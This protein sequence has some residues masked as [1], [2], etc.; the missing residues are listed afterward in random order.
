MHPFREDAEIAREVRRDL[1]SVPGLGDERLDVTVRLG[2]VILSGAISSVARLRE[3]TRVARMVPGVKRIDERVEL[4]PRIESDR[5][6]DLRYRAMDALT[7]HLSLTRPIKVGVVDGWITIAG[8]VEDRFQ[9]D[10]AELALASLFGAS[11]VSNQLTLRRASC[12]SNAS[13]R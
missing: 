5:D 7:R 11:G 12:S 3:A 9:R 6:H 1:D 8:E 2:V 4:R 13:A 10:A